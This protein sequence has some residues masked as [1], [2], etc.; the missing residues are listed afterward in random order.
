MVLVA[1]NLFVI[2]ACFRFRSSR[3][4]F[5]LS[6]NEDIVIEDA[7][8]PFIVPPRLVLLAN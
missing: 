5:L 4:F 6:N 3:I 7:W 8:M 1:E 2:F